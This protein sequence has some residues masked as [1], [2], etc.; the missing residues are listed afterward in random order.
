MN[1]DQ[2]MSNFTVSIFGNLEK[3]SETISKARV[4]IFYKGLNRNR[5]Y[6]T[7]EFAEKLISTLDYTPIKGIYDELDGDF[8]DHGV[9]R[10]NGRIY[11]IVPKDNNFAWEERLDKDGVKRTYA[12][13]DVYLYTGI[14]EEA[15]EIIG[16]SQSMELYQPSLKGEWK[17]I[18]GER[19]FV[20]SEG[21]FLGLQ[22]LGEDVEPCFEGA[23]FFSLMNDLKE[24]YNKLYSVFQID[25]QKGG[26][27]NMPNVCFKLSDN[28][29]ADAIFQLLNPNYNEEGNWELNC[30]LCE[31]YDD[32]ALIY[33]LKHK[34][35]QRVAYTKDD[36]EDSVVLGDRKKYYIVDIT[37]EEKIALDALHAMNGSTFEHLDEKVS[38]LEQEK[39]NFEQKNEE[40]NNSIATLITEKA[41]AEE[42]LEVANNSLN[43]LQTSLNTANNNIA[44]LQSELETLKDYK[45]N[46]EKQEK[47][48]IISQYEDLLSE[49]ILNEYIQK[50]EEIDKE[51]LAK[52]LA[53][54][55][56]QSNPTVFTKTPQFLPKSNT[57]KS[58][59][60]SIL[61]N[62]KK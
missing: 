15:K 46:I 35:Y 10:S 52:E 21:C 43:E 37:E 20:F 19:C 60:E 36:K 57:P 55:L 5:T 2:S 38:N 13:A 49:E 33:D 23:A 34:E 27:N 12:C 62:Y 6:I 54:T 45:L 3:V 58:G 47:E 61:D 7:E 16:K 9:A 31:V 28:E 25:T 41:T 18:E 14:Y 29:K 8:L 26:H 51:T 56:V 1:L 39:A 50:L 17:V 32:Y 30:L 48:A 22:A 40:L 59:I 24:M 53:Y 4:S 42:A 11:G 44:S